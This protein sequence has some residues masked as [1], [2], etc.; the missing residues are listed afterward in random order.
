MD[1]DNLVKVTKG[2]FQ[3]GSDDGHQD[4]RPVHEVEI[5]RDFLISKYPTTFE[6]FDAFCEATGRNKPNDS[7]WGRGERPAINVNWYDA[8]AYC[9]W[10]S[11][12]EGLTPCYTID[13]EQVECDFDANGY[14]LPTEEEW[15]Y[16]ARG[17]TESQGYKYAGS[18]SLE[19]V[20][21]YWGN[22]GGRTH[23]VGEKKPNELGIH[24]MSG[25]V[26]EW[27]WD[28]YDSKAYEKKWKRNI[29]VG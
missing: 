29:I 26:W 4:E 20:G 23:P 1:K 19:D 7:D 17:G 27:C 28:E 16:A 8:I 21:W 6:Q 5:A 24:D 18:N 11:E 25:N 9:N 10:L 13:G 12:K 2:T 3:M 14:R 22:S 15:E